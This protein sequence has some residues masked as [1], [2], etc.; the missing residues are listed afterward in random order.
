MSAQRL[1]LS[2]LTLQRVEGDSAAV[3]AVIA[4]LR[5]SRARLQA[6]DSLIGKMLFL[7]MLRNDL[8]VVAD[9]LQHDLL[10]DAEGQQ[11]Q[12]ALVPLTEPERDMSAAWR[13]ETRFMAAMFSD[14]AMHPE[15][16]HPVKRAAGSVVRALLM[17]PQHSVNL[18]AE[19]HVRWAERDRQSCTALALAEED[20]DPGWPR[21][22]WAYNPV[23]RFLVS[24]QSD[25]DYRIYALRICD[26]DALLRIAHLHAGLKARNI[27]A[28]DWATAVAQAPPE[29]RDPYTARPFTLKDGSALWFDVRGDAERTAALLPWAL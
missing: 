26:V 18:M 4:D 5:Q 27:L 21:W 28:E 22:H 20:A 1:R 3:A 13:Y 2:Q 17:K 19:R 15:Q 7:A 14:A 23:G 9:W 12:T 29:E 24:L 6:A 10:T 11:L 16:E 25:E 8:M